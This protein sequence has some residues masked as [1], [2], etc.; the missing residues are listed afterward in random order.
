MRRGFQIALVIPARNEAAALPGVLSR[1]P[2][3][4]DNVVVVDNGS[5]DETANVAREHGAAVAHEPRRGYGAACWAAM[6]KL[7]DDIEVVLFLDADSSDDLSR[8]PDLI[9]PVY[10]ARMVL[11]LASDDAAMCT[12]NNYMVEAGSI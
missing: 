4:V 1:V 12:A 9:E 3:F 5:T 10:I 6:Q 2:S 8:L 11:F 7:R